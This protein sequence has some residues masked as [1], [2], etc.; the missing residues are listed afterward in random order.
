MLTR[1]KSL[2][3][4][5]SALAMPLVSRTSWA[6]SFPTRPVTLIVPF[7]VGGVTDATLRALATATEPHLGKSIIIE[8]RPGASGT[9][10]PSQMA[11]G[12]SG[13]YVLSQIPAAVFRMPHMTKTSYDP[14]KDFTYIIG[15]CSY[16]FGVVVRSDAPWKTFPEFIA[17]AKANPGKISFGNSGAGAGPHITMER[18]GKQQGIRWT[19]VPFRSLAESTTSLLGGHIDAVADSSG[20]AQL[21][22]E[23][24]LRLLVTWGETRTKR[25]P[26]VPT[27]REIGIDIIL[28]APY[29]IAG[30]KDLGSEVIRILHDAFKKGMEEKPFVEILGQL[31]QEINYMSSAE[32]HAF[33][34]KEIAN[35]K[36]IVDELGLKVN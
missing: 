16:T 27:M 18:I 29:G 36:R 8:N 19:A 17:Y 7:G 32:Y 26:Q 23:G 3:I 10:G 35:E 31:D 22:D 21:V 1:R 24:K 2:Q 4:V 13:G 5:A 25:W 34:I 6:Q 33:A 15:V 28:S 12:R 9:L 14:T 11:S 20:W 30:P